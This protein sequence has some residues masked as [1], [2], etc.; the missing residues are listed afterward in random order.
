LSKTQGSNK[1]QA[2]AVLQPLLGEWTVEIR[3]SAETHRLVGGPSS[4][5]APARF[6]WIEDG[7]FLLHV[8]GGDGAPI[9]RWVIGR[10]E[11]SG[12]YAVLYADDR[13]VSRIYDMSFADRVW[14]IWRESPGFRQRFVGRVSADNRTIEAS[15]EKATNGGA[16]ELDFDLTY[17]RRDAE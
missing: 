14:K 13:G 15:W 7:S 8:T 10:D 1:V 9:A 11:T 2:L 6:Q 12:A 3:W 4:V 17:T 16:W 5:S